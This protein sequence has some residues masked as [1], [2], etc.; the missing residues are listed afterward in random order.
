MAHDDLCETRLAC[1][2]IDFLSRQC[3]PV[4]ERDALRFFVLERPLSLGDGLL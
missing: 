3:C 1:E 2:S 4:D